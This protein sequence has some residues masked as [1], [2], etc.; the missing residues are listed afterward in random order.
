MGR[1]LAGTETEYGLYVEDRGAEDQV[2]DAMALVRGYPGECHVG[3]NYR[4]ESPRADLRG[5][6]LERL[7]IDPEDVKFDAGRKHPPDPD[8]RSDR[9]L[10]NGA[11]FYN[12]HG[13]PE[14][15]TPECWSARELALQ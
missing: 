12:D 11:R 10:P 1:I 15:S 8:I 5:F 14:Y 7:A 6:V 9:V 13:H 3:W 2:D 4:Y